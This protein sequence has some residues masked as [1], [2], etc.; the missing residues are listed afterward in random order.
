MIFR[1]Q[2]IDNLNDS[3]HNNDPIYLVIQYFIHS[4]E[5]RNKEIQACLK[6]NIELGIFSKVIMLNERIYSYSELGLDEGDMN[7]ILQVDIS[8]R[9]TYSKAFEEIEKLSL[10]VGYFVICN[11]DI[12]FDKTVLNVRRSCLSKR[13][14]LYA[15]I[16]F[17]Y[18][19]KDL[20]KCRMFHYNIDTCD[21]SQDVWIYHS[22][23]KPNNKVK[24]KS[25]FHFGK[26]G[27]DNKISFVFASEGYKCINTP[28]N[29][30]SY[31]YH[32]SNIRSYTLK[33]KV[34]P[35]YLLLTPVITLI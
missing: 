9:L 20:D 24:E 11:S 18:D 15:L 5:T 35:P 27:C 29:V 14:S 13:K 3:P 1:Q 22:N 17:E 21:N 10:G 30:K 31:H 26:P 2:N 8:S 12:F 6:K 4:N 34:P 7:H 32:T 16:R 25:N 33:D 28:Y 19:N 23:F